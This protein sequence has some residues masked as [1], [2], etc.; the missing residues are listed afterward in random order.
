MKKL[1]LLIS[2]L[3][4]AVVFVAWQNPVLAAVD[5]AHAPVAAPSA[6]TVLAPLPLAPLA[7]QLGQTI[8]TIMNPSAQA[9]TTSNT[10][11]EDNGAE[12]SGSFTSGMFDALAKTADNLKAKGETLAAQAAAWPDFI[13]WLTVQQ[14]DPRRQALWSMIG[15]DLLII[16]GVPFVGGAAL[17]FLLLPLRFHLRRGQ[18]VSLPGRVG[19]MLGL[20]VLRSIPVIVFLGAGLLLLNQNETHALPRFVVLNVIYALALAYAIRQVLRGVLS[21]TVDYL[22]FITFTKSQAIY[23]FRWLSSFAFVIVYGYFLIT[24]AVALR[25]P[26]NAVSFFQNVFGLVLTIMAIVVILHTQTRVAAILQGKEPLD[27]HSFKDALR[28]WLARHWHR[29]ATAYLVFGLI[30]IWLSVN[31]GIALMLRGTI[32]TIVL[33]VAARGGFVV[34]ARWAAPTFNSAALPHRQILA[35][36]LRLLIWVSLAVGIATVW[37][38]PL[39]GTISTPAGQRAVNAFLT[40][41]LTLLILTAVYETLHMWIERYLT[42]CDKDSD[43]PVASA[44][45]R[46]LLPMVRNTVLIFFSGAAILTCLSAA[47]VN[48]QPLLA[49]VGVVGVAIGFGSQTLVKDFLTGLFIVVENTIAVGDAV[50]IG[51]FSGSVEAM[52][53]RTIR[54]RDSEGTLHI[55]PFSEVSKISNMSKGF[56][57]ALVDVGVAYNSDLD[58]VMN[59]LREIGAQLQEDAV[60]KRVILEPIEVMGVE[61]LADSAVIIRARIRTRP[62]KQWDVRRLLLQRIKQRF[63]VEKISIPYPTITHIVTE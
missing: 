14:T 22:R 3:L 40:A 38:F 15:N 8:Q 31:N 54:L 62:G 11:E 16:V 44:R 58:H 60:F 50:K 32:L 27:R 61:K 37:G 53:I 47:G 29:L 1:R 35:F 48:I 43:Q 39:G 10:E 13:N 55:L 56:A 9:P 33:L 41:M 25:V 4:F 30:V 57:Y 59:V 42:R 17:S 52:S 49:G 36:F 34:L 21:P 23:A 19:L 7:T 63:E 5:A 12:L 45:A 24:V 26:T 6:P 2:F 18:P 51:E 20:F 46:T 28:G